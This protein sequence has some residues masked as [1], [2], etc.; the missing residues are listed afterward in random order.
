MNKKIE[1]QRNEITETL[2][3]AMEAGINPWVANFNNYNG[4]TGNRYNGNNILR[5]QAARLQ[6]GFKDPRWMTFNQAVSKG[7]HIKKGSKSTNLET[8]VEVVDKYSSI[9][10]VN[11]TDEQNAEFNKKKVMV[12]FKVFN[13]EQIDGLA[14]I[15]IPQ[16]T[17][18]Q[19]NTLIKLVEEKMDLKIVMWTHSDLPNYQPLK[20]TIFINPMEAFKEN[21]FALTLLHEVAHATQHSKRLNDDTRKYNTIEERAK[22]ELI[23]ELSAT[24]IAFD[25]GL[26]LGDFGIKN[27]AS[28]LDSWLKALK[29]DKNYIWEVAKKANKVASYV[30]EKLDFSFNNDFTSNLIEKDEQAK[31]E[32]ISDVKIESEKVNLDSETTI[33]KTISETIETS[34]I[35]ETKEQEAIDK[36]DSKLQQLIKSHSINFTG[37]SK[38]E[39]D[40]R[41]EEAAND[42]QPKLE[43]YHKY[44]KGKDE[45]NIAFMSDAEAKSDKPYHLKKEEQFTTIATHVNHEGKVISET[46]ISKT[47]NKMVHIYFDEAEAL[48]AYEE[49]LKAAKSKRKKTEQEQILMAKP[50]ASN[51]DNETEEVTYKFELISEHESIKELA[52]KKIEAAK[53]RAKK[54][55][56]AQ[57]SAKTNLNSEA[58]AN[59]N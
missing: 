27:S 52:I 4:L 56:Q 41:I 5:L 13:A 2:I 29:A 28:Y 18:E 17:V 21:E 19:N 43:T 59:T 42:D 49:A 40:V 48:K 38:K 53:A 11:L 54:R 16:M 47:D 37:L 44:V 22:E 57:T 7:L 58:L 31:S 14:K 33:I 25:L 24:M 35:N 12:N 9:K 45:S 50:I 26:N 46:A 20:D 1:D 15:E 55:T 8:L 51:S 6:Q 39:E 32:T 30:K 34:K 3:K 36:A 10:I 23:A